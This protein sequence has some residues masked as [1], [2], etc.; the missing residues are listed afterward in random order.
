M[1]KN[2]NN[3]NFSVVYIVLTYGAADVF[4]AFILFKVLFVD[5]HFIIALISFNNNINKLNL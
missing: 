4:L 3:F 1:L 5:F 2:K